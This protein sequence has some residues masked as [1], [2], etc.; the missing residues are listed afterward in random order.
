MVLP[1]QAL[2][3]GVITHT[4]A[5]NCK[6]C[7]CRQHA[8]I[9]CRAKQAL[10]VGMI[11]GVFVLEDFV[12]AGWQEQEQLKHVNRID[13]EPCGTK[14]CASSCFPTLSDNN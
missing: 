7:M 1:P 5:Q 13:T 11:A 14:Q 9:C 4:K 12:M 10:E 6:H 2:K 8:Y 3:M